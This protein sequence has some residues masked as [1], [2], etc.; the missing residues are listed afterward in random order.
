MASSFVKKR[1]DYEK[2]MED[3]RN[4]KQI[5]FKAELKKYRKR[6]EK[7]LSYTVQQC[8]DVM[9]IDDKKLVALE[10][11]FYARNGKYHRLKAINYDSNSKVLERG[12]NKNN[13][14]TQEYIADQSASNPH[15]AFGK[16]PID[17]V[18]VKQDYLSENSK[19]PP[20]IVTPFQDKG[21]K[22][23]KNTQSLK[24]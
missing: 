8:E 2:L 3:E 1:K 4:K 13:L 6:T 7:K 21:S 23:V 12:Q 18:E 19:R 9:F 17:F 22:K 14:G 10:Y 11:I 20:E 5:D 15:N 24:K 16:M